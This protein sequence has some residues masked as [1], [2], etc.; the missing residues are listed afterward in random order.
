MYYRLL[1][2]H[3]LASHVRKR[4][5]TDQCLPINQTT[6]FHL[7]CCMPYSTSSRNRILHHHRSR[8]RRWFRFKRL[9]NIKYTYISCCIM[10][11]KLVLCTF[12]IRNAIIFRGY[13]QLLLM[14]C[15]VF[16]HFQRFY[17]QD[18]PS[19]LLMEIVV[20]KEQ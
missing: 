8:C 17:C 3:R 12:N 11:T 9:Q 14:S 5:M 10:P 2:P 18:L 20:L 6:L 16:G 19:L 4:P 7:F 1:L 13:I 15:S